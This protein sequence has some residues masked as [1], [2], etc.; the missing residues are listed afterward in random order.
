M[1]AAAIPADGIDCLDVKRKGGLI[2]K[3]YV[4]NPYEFNAFSTVCDMETEYGGWTVFLKSSQA[5]N[6]TRLKWNEYVFGYGRLDGDFWLG[7]EKIHWLT[8]RR[9]NTILRIEISDNDEMDYYEYKDFNIDGA[10]QNYQP[11][12]SLTEEDKR[13]LLETKNEI[14]SEEDLI[15]KHLSL[16]HI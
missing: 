5:N 11:H 13:C 4:I 16:I 8:E 15:P 3:I 10:A 9:T 1:H 7:L 12:I 6:I 14:P 2:S